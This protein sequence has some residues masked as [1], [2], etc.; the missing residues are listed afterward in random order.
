MG[1]RHRI[2]FIFWLWRV[3]V[4]ARRLSLVAV[5]RVSL[6]VPVCGLLT[7]VASLLMEHRL[8]DAQASVTV[9]YELSCATA[10]RIFPDQRLNLCPMYCKADS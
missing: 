10:C 6:F 5:N 4:A 1:G 9:A 2:Y 8:S 3:S 7:A